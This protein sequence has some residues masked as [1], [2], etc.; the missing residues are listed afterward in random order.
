MIIG[1]FLCLSI[2][3]HRYVSLLIFTLSAIIILLTGIPSFGVCLVIRLWPSICFTIG[4]ISS[5]LKI[6]LREI[7]GLKTD[8]TSILS[9]NVHPAFK[10][11]VEMAFSS[12]SS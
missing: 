8:G 7:M 11:V 5:R 1:P 9:G 3:M 4:V 12:A 6:N 2:S 10:A